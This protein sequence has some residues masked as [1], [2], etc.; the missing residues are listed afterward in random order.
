MSDPV[1]PELSNTIVATLLPPDPTVALQQ[2][3]SSLKTQLLIAKN[4][5]WQAKNNPD[6][7]RA[8]SVVIVDLV[9]NARGDTHHSNYSDDDIRQ[10]VA[11]LVEEDSHDCWTPEREYTFTM[12]MEVTLRGNIFGKDEDTVREWIE[13]NLPSYKLTNIGAQ[14]DSLVIDD[15][16]LSDLEI[17]AE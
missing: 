17:E 11:Y 12:K 15:E 16:V 10:R 5:I 14:Y 3:I 13:E 6:L 9:E 8:W 1:T 7:S 4:D 2:E